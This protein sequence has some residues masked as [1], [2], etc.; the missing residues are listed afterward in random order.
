MTSVSKSLYSDKLD[1]IMNKNSNTYHGKIKMKPVDV[2]SN[3]YI[4]F[5]KENDE[6][7]PK[8]DMYYQWY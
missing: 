5:N 6:E 3:T 1:D 8:F 4:D 2:Y 7:D